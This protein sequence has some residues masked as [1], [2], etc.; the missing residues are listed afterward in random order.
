M[1]KN[2]NLGPGSKKIIL[3]K[4]DKMYFEHPSEGTK[5]LDVSTGKFFK[6]EIQEI[7]SRSGKVK[8]SKNPL[9]N[10]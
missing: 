10:F 8:N 5:F 3:K 2:K 6:P 9:I 4:S 1:K 7:F